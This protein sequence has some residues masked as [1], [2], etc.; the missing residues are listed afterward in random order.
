MKTTLRSNEMSCP[1]CVNSIETFLNK[2]D[3]ITGATVYFNTGKIEVEHDAGK[4]SEQELVDAVR[5]V[6]YESDVS[7]F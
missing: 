7:V 2:I 5:K 1:T 4:V 6:G 3:G